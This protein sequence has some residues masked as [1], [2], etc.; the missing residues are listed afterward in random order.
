MATET[1]G[2]MTCPECGGQADVK[3][4]PAEDGK[5]KYAFRWCGACRAQYFP[6]S[7]AAEA[8]LLAKIGQGIPSPVPAGPAPTPAPGSPAPGAKPKPAPGLFST[9]FRATEA[10]E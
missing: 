9:I 8:Q 7:A 10:A 4:K 5:A 1:L 2:R 3:R 6:R